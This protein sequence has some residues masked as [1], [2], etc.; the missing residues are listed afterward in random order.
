MLVKELA[1]RDVRWKSKT[2]MRCRITSITGR[3]DVS[4]AMITGESRPVSK[5]PGAQVIGGTINSEAGHVLGHRRCWSEPTDLRI[6][7]NRR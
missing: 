4:E 1:R 2:L 6:R 7:E 5:E 3:P